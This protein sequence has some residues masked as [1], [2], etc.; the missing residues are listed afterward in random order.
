MRREGL[1]GL[2]SVLA[3]RNKLEINEYIVPSFEIRKTKKIRPEIRIRV[4]NPSQIGDFS[5]KVIIPYEKAFELPSDFDK[6]RVILE[7]PFLIY[8]H[9]EEKVK[10]ELKALF[11][12]I[13]RIGF[14]RF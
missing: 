9:D 7:I 8:P 12:K 1:D 2:F 6:E 11:G 13:E 5:G 4:E 10:E 3:E 14:Y